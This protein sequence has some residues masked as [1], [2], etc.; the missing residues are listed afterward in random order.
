VLGLKFSNSRLDKISV[1]DMA[2]IVLGESSKLSRATK[3]FRA[4]N[5]ARAV[6]L[7][8]NMVG[9]DGLFFNVHFERVFEAFAI[10]PSVL[11]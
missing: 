9:W 1:N 2:C 11:Q 4:C 8:P 6:Y 10:I 3:C 5:G 7:D